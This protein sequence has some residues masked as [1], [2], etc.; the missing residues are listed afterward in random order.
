MLKYT[1][2]GSLV[3]HLVNEDVIVK[4]FYLKNSDVS[5]TIIDFVNDLKI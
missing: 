1:G 3:Q 2:V 5:P 4:Y